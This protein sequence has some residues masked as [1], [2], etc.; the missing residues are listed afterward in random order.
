MIL[1]FN[2]KV[3]MSDWLDVDSLSLMLSIKFSG[4]PEICLVFLM[5]EDFDLLL[6]DGFF[7]FVFDL[8]RAFVTLPILLDFLD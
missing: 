2:L 1:L 6:V 5:D 4:A 3:A 7:A 8:F